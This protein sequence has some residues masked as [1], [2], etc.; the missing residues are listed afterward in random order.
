MSS[1]NNVSWD[2]FYPVP[3]IAQQ[4]VDII[5]DPHLTFQN[6]Y[7]KKVTLQNNVS[8]AWDSE[9]LEGKYVIL[10]IFLPQAPR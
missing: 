6:I 5:T 3:F 8:H 4:V 9:H 10:V 7:V 1:S 2:M